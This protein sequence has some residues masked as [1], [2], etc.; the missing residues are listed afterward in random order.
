[1]NYVLTMLANWGFEWAKKKLD[2]RAADT[3][4]ASKKVSVLRAEGDA[5]AD[6]DRAGDAADDAL[7]AAAEAAERK[8][9]GG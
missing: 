6:A 5:M 9:R 2:E 8:K 1:M 3:A 7:R 4:E